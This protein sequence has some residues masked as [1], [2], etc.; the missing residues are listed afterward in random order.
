MGDA[1]RGSSQALGERGIFPMPE[2]LEESAG[3]SSVGM[4]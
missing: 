3:V 1:N 2:R 4:S